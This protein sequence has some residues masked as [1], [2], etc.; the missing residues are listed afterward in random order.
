[1]RAIVEDLLEALRMAEGV[2]AN[3]G[4]K[5]NASAAAIATH[6]AGA[7]RRAEAA[8][9]DPVERRVLLRHS[10]VD[11]QLTAE[12]AYTG[13]AGVYD[14]ARVSIV[15]ATG[16]CVADLVVGLDTSGELR[17]LATANSDG[18]GDHPIAIY[19]LRGIVDAVTIDARGN[20]LA[21]GLR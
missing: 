2:A 3:G 20:A 5:G 14:E 8:L 13:D 9:K 19:P 17:V 10:G 1:M 18:D 6:A 15:N 11:A 12:M 16:E 4:D 21:P 7:I